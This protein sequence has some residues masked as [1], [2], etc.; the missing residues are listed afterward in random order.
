MA[1][2]PGHEV[3]CEN[4]TAMYARSGIIMWKVDMYSEDK[5]CI[6]VKEFMY[7]QQL[8]SGLDLVNTT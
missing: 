5:L 2:D 3:L 4:I 8:N 7:M 6:A 1:T